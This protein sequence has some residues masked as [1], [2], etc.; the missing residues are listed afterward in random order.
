M[1]GFMNELGW[2]NCRLCTNRFIL[3]GFR[4]QYCP[5]CGWKMVKW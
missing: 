3:D 5:R 4:V 1:K 2:V